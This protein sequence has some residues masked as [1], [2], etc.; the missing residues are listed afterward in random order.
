[1]AWLICGQFAP[2]GNTSVNVQP[3]VIFYIGVQGAA[4]GT[5][6]DYSYVSTLP[7]VIDFAKAPGQYGAI[8]THHADGSFD[9]G[10]TSTRAEH[11]YLIE[12]MESANSP[13]GKDLK[14]LKDQ[15]YASPLQSFLLLSLIEY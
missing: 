11:L 2:Q 6:F 8:I 14:E 3:N 7:A 10:F 13:M 1:M 12:R 15:L 4:T 9:V 5:A